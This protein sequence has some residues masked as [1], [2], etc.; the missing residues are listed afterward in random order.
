MLL[1]HSL[2]KSSPPPRRR[3]SAAGRRGAAVCACTLRHSTPGMQAQGTHDAAIIEAAS[4]GGRGVD[5]FHDVQC[6]ERFRHTATR[7][8]RTW[9]PFEQR[10]SRTVLLR[11]HISGP[12]QSSCR[13]PKTKPRLRGPGRSQNA[14]CVSGTSGRVIHLELDGMR[15]V[16]EAVHLAPLQLDVA[17][18]LLGVEHVAREQ[19]VVVGLERAQAPRAGCRT[20][21]G[22][23]SALPAA[24]RRDP[25]PSGRPDGFCCGCRPAR[26][27]AAPNT[28]DRGSRSRPGSG[29]RRAWP[30][31]WSCT[32]C[33]RTRSGCGP[34]RPAAPAPRNP[35]ISR[36]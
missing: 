34:N 13:L 14:R 23:P 7:Q 31:G 8:A 32:G 10:L 20:P 12:A 3:L 27:S 19:E 28:P 36:L 21:S 11:S 15:R 2:E 22:C 6:C 29:S 30:S 35:G 1:A 9:A 33:G 26:P 24:S 5:W 18:D 4:K 25:C 16:L 17:A